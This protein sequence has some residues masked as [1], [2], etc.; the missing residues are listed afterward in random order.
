MSQSLFDHSPDLTR[1]RNEGYNVEVKSGFL[2]VKDVPYVNSN[3]EIKRG[4]L[5]STLAMAGDVVVQP[6]SHVVFFVGDHPCTQNGLEIAAIKNSSQ[7]QSLADGLI[8]SHMFSAKPPSGKYDDYYHKMKTYAA[9]IS[10]FAQAID[11][12]VTAKTF[13]VVEAGEDEGVFNYADQASSRARIGP[14]AAKLALN[15][16]GIVGLGGTGSYVL[17]FV[18][19]TPVRAI[20]IFDGDDLLNHNA[21]RSPGAPSLDEL[22][23]RPKKVAYLR[24]KYSKMHRNIVPHDCF[25]DGTNVEELRAM[26]FVFLCIDRGE[27]KRA[28]VSNLEAWGIPFVDVGMGI[29]L[30]NGAL[31]AILRITTS[32]SSQREHVWKKHRIPFSVGAEEDDYSSNIQIADLNALNAALAVIKWKKL[33]GFYHDLE[34]EYFSTYTITGNSMTNEDQL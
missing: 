16:V 19:K 30:I 9:I 7:Q 25:I 21:F 26:S 27:D 15:Q 18:S 2:L 24:D 34:Q 28:I 6:D 14:V 17:D 33:F 20:H 3:K 11:P 10:G 32:T 29:D 13:Q 22:R 23:E 12:S 4:I 5:V 31:T 1:L 8:V